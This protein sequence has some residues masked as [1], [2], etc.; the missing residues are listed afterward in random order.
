M[1]LSI[2][3]IVDLG[4]GPPPIVGRILVEGGL[5]IFRVERRNR[6]EYRFYSVLQGLFFN[7]PEIAD[8]FPRRDTGPQT[9]RADENQYV[10]R[11][12]WQDIFFKALGSHG[13]RIA[14][15]R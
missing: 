7:L 9:V 10:R 15:L 13:T 4:N 6:Q 12:E 1:N 14:A 8:D 5:D 11:L 3:I 2:D